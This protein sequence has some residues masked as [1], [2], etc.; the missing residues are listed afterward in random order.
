MQ[1]TEDLDTGP[2]YFM[3]KEIE[4]RNLDG[5]TGKYYKI[6]VLKEKLIEMLKKENI[7][8]PKGCLQHLQQQCIGLNLPTSVQEP[9]IREEGWVNK[10]KGAFQILFK[11]GWKDPSNIH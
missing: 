10:P 9:I 5:Q 7:L 6:R 1:L 2:F 4:D 11:H 8:N 3:K